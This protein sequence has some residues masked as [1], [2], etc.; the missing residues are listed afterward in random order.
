MCHAYSCVTTF[1]AG[2]MKQGVQ[3]AS[4]VVLDVAI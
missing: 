3:I 1:F 4:R 2:F